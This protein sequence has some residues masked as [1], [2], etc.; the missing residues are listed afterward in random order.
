[1]CLQTTTLAAFQIAVSFALGNNACGFTHFSS[2]VIDGHKNPSCSAGSGARRRLCDRDRL[3]KCHPRTARRSP[4]DCRSCAERGERCATHCYAGA[5]GCL[6]CAEHR[7]PGPAGGA[8]SSSML[9]CD[10]SATGS[11]VRAVSAQV[12][13]LELSGSP[14]RA[15]LFS[16][17]P[18]R[19]RFFCASPICELAPV[20]LGGTGRKRLSA[21]AADR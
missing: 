21:S 9:R 2:G 11:H 20:G 17:P 7:E 12:I 5:A 4:C 1:M 19:R 8:G 14:R 6:E 16:K 10:E 3:R 18:L 15:A 13:E